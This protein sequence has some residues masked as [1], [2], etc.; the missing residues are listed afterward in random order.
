MSILQDDI[1]MSYKN[2]LNLDILEHHLRYI[3]CVFDS[4]CDEM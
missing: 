2:I 3:L 4:V 1:Q